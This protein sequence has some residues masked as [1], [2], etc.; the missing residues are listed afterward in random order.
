MRFL[1]ASLPVC[2]AWSIIAC[3]GDTPSGTRVDAALPDAAHDG[4][5]KDGRGDGPA[6]DGDA[7]MSHDTQGGEALPDAGVPACLA[8]ELN[9]TALAGDVVDPGV[10]TAKVT[11]TTG[12]DCL[13]SYTISSTVQLLDGVPGN[14]RTVVEVADGPALRSG[15]TMF[16][17]LYALALA[18]VKE[19]S[20]AAIKDG[21]FNGGNPIPCPAGGCFETGRKWNYVWTRDTAYAATLGLALIDPTRTRNSLA[22]KL[23]ELRSGGGRQIV[24]DTG[25]GG[26]YPISSDRV[27]WALGA[28]A[29]LQTLDGAARQTFRDL[30][31]EALVNTLE[32]D[33]KTVYDATDGL[34]RG[35][36]SFL[37]WREQSY[38]A[39]VKDDPVHIGM[40][41]ALSTNVGHLRALELAATLAAEKGESAAATKYRGQADQL[42]AAIGQRFW[43][44]DV[45]LFSTFLTTSLD[46]APVHHFDLLGSA[47][48]VLADVG[49]AQQRAQVVAHY[50]HLPKG[51]PVIWPAQKE[52][53]IYH[54]RALWPFVTAFWL[55]A[56][57]KVRNDAA[58]DRGVAS[59]LRGA[60]LNLSNMENLEQVSG[61]PWVDDGLYSGPQV[62]SQRQLWSV[63]GY[64]SMVHEVIF[65]L[66]QNA[67]GLRFAP[68][69]T[70]ALRH[71]LFAAADTLV[72][73]NLPYRG[74]LVTVRLRLPAKTG[75]PTLGGAY[76]VASVALNGKAVAKDSVFGSAQLALPRNLVEIV[77]TD[78]WDAGASITEV[79]D[80]GDPKR[81]FAPKNPRLNSLTLAGGKLQLGF[82]ANGENAADIAFN[83]YRDGVRI[84]TALPGN[85]T[86]YTDQQSSSSSPSYCYVIESYYLGSK[87]H[88]QHSPPS[89]YWGLGGERVTSVLAATMTNVG[90]QGS[91][92]HGRFHY[93]PWGD[94]SHSL[95][96]SSFAPKVSGPHLLQVVAGN[97]AGPIST[98]ITCAVKRVIVEELPVGTL[99][100]E[101]L[102]VMPH[103]G[104]WAV[105]RDS[106]FVRVELDA[107]KSYRIVIKSDPQALNMSSFAHFNTYAGEGGAAGTFN[108]VNIAELKILA[109]QP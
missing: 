80:N 76:A 82:D 25:T 70:R 46:P 106:S 74:K 11:A 108:R 61:K 89:C 10:G 21:A 49:T 5:R 98:G 50:P 1:T 81:L 63:A 66:E 109:L 45:G 3:G 53:P 6:I 78:T 18:E 75:G 79:T 57:A 22:F 90:G 91:N 97:G 92:N 9:G 4:A 41:K 34:Y 12:S 67:Q 48:A 40:S 68:Y 17:A 7:A 23:S 72:L 52:V 26:S 13:R 60:A 96:V 16:D 55:R 19:N 86:S 85:A 51:A 65:G 42:R 103:L 102:F 15:N 69:I 104:T 29:V 100:G 33:G 54:N 99:V 59:L 71:D 8:A 105:W 39:W 43:L 44:S 93:E 47:L 27:V 38:P 94:D 36:Q 28:E 58:V 30:T 20:V 2:V 88:S 101:G 31:Y 84:G 87:N 24:Q 62:N 14:P 32:H 107:T 37:D 73:N 77:L 35:E 83:V 95:T 64:L 56:A